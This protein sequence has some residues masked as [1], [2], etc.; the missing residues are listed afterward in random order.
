MICIQTVKRYCKDDISLIENYEKA[1]N[2][3]ENIWDIHHRLETE[4]GVSKQ[5]LIDNNIYYNRSASEL[6]FLTHS[7]HQK[8]HSIGRTFSEETIKKLSETH[9]GYKH[10]EESKKKMS[11]AKKGKKQSSELINKRINGIKKYYEYNNGYWKDK[12]L[13]D[14]TKKKMSDSH[15]G[16][17]PSNLTDLHEHL[18][19]YGSPIKGKHRVYDIN[20]KYH[21]V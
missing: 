8:L 18:K 19:L 20:G 11:E 21:Y 7:E 17:C 1:L 13:S 2:D 3:N 4:L 6:I 12:N 10:T 16:R 5:Y 15:K 14:E 9:K